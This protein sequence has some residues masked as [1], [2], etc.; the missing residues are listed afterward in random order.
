VAAL[1]C[2]QFTREL[3]ERSTDDILDIIGTAQHQ[4]RI[5]WNVIQNVFIIRAAKLELDERLEQSKARRNT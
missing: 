2:A 3:K 5:G 4:V 1:D